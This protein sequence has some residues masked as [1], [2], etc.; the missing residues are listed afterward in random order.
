[1]LELLVVFC[2][3]TVWA[4]TRAIIQIERHMAS[5]TLGKLIGAISILGRNG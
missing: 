1:M 2:G 4:D 3:A 5:K